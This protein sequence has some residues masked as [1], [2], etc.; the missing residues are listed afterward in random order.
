MVRRETRRGSGLL[1][2]FI[3]IAF[4]RAPTGDRGLPPNLKAAGE[5]VSRRRRLRE[6][7]LNRIPLDVRKPVDANAP[8]RSQANIVIVGRGMLLAVD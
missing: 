2:F 5:S 7:K 6:A 3:A 8:L 1:D 4:K